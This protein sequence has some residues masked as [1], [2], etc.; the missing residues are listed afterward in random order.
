[1]SS[2]TATVKRLDQGIN[3]SGPTYRGA[4]AIM[5]LAD[6]RSSGKWAFMQPLHWSVWVALLVSAFVVPVI[7]VVLERVLSGR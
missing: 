6:V 5:V 2:I 3:F 1:M 7:V 4:L